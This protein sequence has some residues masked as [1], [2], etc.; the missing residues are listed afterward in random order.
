[1]IISMLGESDIILRHFDEPGF[2]IDV[3]ENVQAHYSAMQM[4]ATSLGLC[5]ASLL[6][7]Y[8][9]QFDT[10]IDDLS[11]RVRWTYA[12]DPYRVDQIDM[13]LQWPSLPSDRIRAAERVAQRCTIHNTLHHEPSIETRVETRTGR[14]QH[15]R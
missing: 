12:D 4:F 14:D 9:D 5:T 13:S 3:D 11:V 2:E 6:A 1:M 15:P 10:D 7:S 8:G